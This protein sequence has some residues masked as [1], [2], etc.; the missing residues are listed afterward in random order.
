MNVASSATVM[1]THV[2]RRACAGFDPE[3][4]SADSIGSI[5]MSG[6]SE[7]ECGAVASPPNHQPEL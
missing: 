7:F 2:L 3:E 6:H 4:L 5:S 1:A